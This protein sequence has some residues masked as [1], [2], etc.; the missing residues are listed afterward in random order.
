MK[1]HRK[2]PSDASAVS[3]NELRSQWLEFASTGRLGAARSLL[4]RANLSNLHA[5][6]LARH[7]YAL[8]CLGLCHR[9]DGAERDDNEEASEAGRLVGEAVGAGVL[10]ASNL[11]CFRA[12]AEHRCDGYG[13]TQTKPSAEQFRDD[14]A[15]EFV[16]SLAASPAGERFGLHAV[17]ELWNVELCTSQLVAEQGGIPV[18]A[19]G[20]RLPLGPALADSLDLI[21]AVK[22]WI[23]GTPHVPLSAK[24]SPELLEKL[25]R[26][27]LDADDFGVG[28]QDT[29]LSRLR[30]L[31]GPL[32]PATVLLERGQFADVLD[33][34]RRANASESNFIQTPEELHWLEWT[35][36]E[37]M[38]AC[39]LKTARE[40][41]GRVPIDMTLLKREWEEILDDAGTYGFRF[42]MARQLAGVALARARALFEERSNEQR[43]DATGD[44]R[45]NSE[46]SEEGIELLRMAQALTSTP[47]IERELPERLYGLGRDECLRKNWSKGF[48][49]Y[50]DCLQLI[51]A[52]NVAHDLVS[53]VGKYA[54]MIAK[55]NATSAAVEAMVQTVVEVCDRLRR[56]AEGGSSAKLPEDLI[57]LQVAATTPL[58]TLV[59]EACGRSQFE[60]ATHRML[61]A[62]RIAA[63]SPDVQSDCRVLLKLL[64]REVE[65]GNMAAIS[66]RDHIETAVQAATP[67]RLSIH[68]NA[69]ES[70]RRKSTVEDQLAAGTEH[71]FQAALEDA[72][73]ER[74]AEAVSKLRSVLEAAP[75]ANSV[76]QAGRRIAA[77]WLKQSTLQKRADEFLAACR[78]QEEF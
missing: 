4:R 57:E 73:A 43:R 19:F 14:F 30:Q 39:H 28:V 18:D 56:L 1:A 54:K 46:R 38:I 45:T 5:C 9:H 27:R 49:S 44:R 35:R 59:R 10:F 34:L 70:R 47:E 15:N 62:L 6:D 33:A 16:N 74:F 72:E 52:E 75:F 63:E 68:T 40:H 21:D 64:N 50:L 32:G 67:G 55:Q 65:T 76:R 31:F 69:A 23:G 78:A 22:R 2:S 51:P 53:D 11:E 12:F 41:V 66:W 36:R 24:L 58:L 77:L 13:P 3:L 60:E 71:L 17:W 26:S 8:V 29:P 25:G 7:T 37:L 20:F 61:D 42:V 48:A